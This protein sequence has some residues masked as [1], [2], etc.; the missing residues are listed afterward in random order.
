MFGYITSCFL[1]AKI[2]ENGVGGG[3]T[4]AAADGTLHGVVMGPI[5]EQVVSKSLNALRARHWLRGL[6]NLQ[7]PKSCRSSCAPLRCHF[8]S[9]RVL[10]RCLFSSPHA[11]YERQRLQWLTQTFNGLVVMVPH[12]NRCS[13]ERTAFQA[14]GPHT[15]CQCCLFHLLTHGDSSANTLFSQ[16]M[17]T[18]APMCFIRPQSSK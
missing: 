5:S 11:I 8:S 9:V 14:L 13:F 7:A 1:R 12:L 18:A 6:E 3:S 4:C 10:S 16:G 2:S 15:V 17:L